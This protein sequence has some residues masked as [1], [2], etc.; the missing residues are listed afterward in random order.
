MGKEKMQNE[1]PLILIA[2][3]S[4]EMLVQLQHILDKDNY[5]IVTASNGK[6]ALEVFQKSNPE[7][8]ILDV[9]MPVMDGITACKKLRQ[10]P[11]GN[12]VPVL[13]ITAFDDPKSIEDSYAAGADEYI[14]KP[15]HWA[16]LSYK[17]ARL[18]KAYSQN[19]K[20]TVLEAN[21]EDLYNNSPDM[22][23]SVDFE[24]TRIIQCN[25]TLATTLG[26]TKEEVIGKSVFDLYHS[27]CMDD[28][29]E[30]YQTVVKN[31]V[32]KNAELK[33][34]KRDNT[35]IDVILNAS[36][37]RDKAGKIL[38][39]RS[40]WRDITE[41]KK[42]SDALQKAKDEL[43]DRVQLRTVEL[44]QSNKELLA[45]I[46][47]HQL[48]EQELRDSEQR[49]RSVIETSHDAIILTDSGGRVATV[50]NGA[51]TIFGY[52]LEELIGKSLTILLPERYRA[53]HEKGMA[54]VLE[55]GISEYIGNVFEFTGLRKDGSEFPFEL[56]VSSWASN[57]DLFFSGILRDISDRKATEEETI[58][59]ETKLAQSQ[60]MEAIGTLA[61]GIAHDF[62]NILMAVL[63]Y[64]GMI[65]DKAEPGSQILSDVEQIINAGHR[66]KDLVSQ[67]LAFSRQSDHELM[68][69]RIQYVLKE[70]LKL[71]RSSIPT[72][73]EIKQN[74]DSK[75]GTV[76]ADPSQI[77][78]II[79]NLCTNAYHAMRK[80]GGI[81]DI[82]LT[83]LNLSSEDTL[84]KIFL[85]PGP[86][87]KLSI[88][89]N[90]HGM[91]RNV[92]AKIFN[93]YFTTKIMGEGTG[94]GLSVVHG[95]VKSFSGDINVYSEPGKGTTFNIYLPVVQAKEEKILEES[96]LPLPRGDERILTVDDD[97][98]LVLMNQK[99]LESLGYTVTATTSSVDALK[100]FRE[101][102]YDFDLVLT[103]MTMPQMH[104]IELAKQIFGVRANIP[105]I[106]CTGFSE[107]I[108]DEKAKT[109]GIRGFIMK[110]VLKSD[111]ARSVRKALDG[112]N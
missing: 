72:T 95:L 73:I 49:F 46:K 39:C 80:T 40:S 91:T 13:M 35:T 67:I 98:S 62:N 76:M 25:Q 20:I 37:I 23:V 7:V 26:Y 83:P 60:K 84:G 15:L 82:S 103:D 43:E 109:L 112:K 78:Q 16:V 50:N 19:K 89:D 71:L 48:T 52:K 99:I 65:R 111:L 107:L 6:E 105:I 53:D 74:F 106:I 32:V 41:R 56:G 55:T 17:I 38:H 12:D 104:G 85:Q 2:D 90:G 59:L 66:A 92:M 61:G 77:H 87:V 86:Y 64:S 5:Q 108:N 30:A 14:N 58:K 70:A 68:P 42:A 69:I 8:V 100:L 9:A 31:G 57:D 28:A 96:V 29:K 10:L 24:N 51:E 102:P 47:E 75:C 101:Q 33:L 27:D 18:Y 45:K 11:R 110:P 79:M 97:E 3:D 81:L 63:G 21:Y 22:Y 88:S 54:R 1:K 93:P 44:V 94:L 4:E 36:A 34:Q